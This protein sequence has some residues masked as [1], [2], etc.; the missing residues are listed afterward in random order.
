MDKS[1]PIPDI[2][3][4]KAT[5]PETKKQKRTRT[6]IAGVQVRQPFF[7]PGRGVVEAESLEEAIKQPQQEEVEH[8]NK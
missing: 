3:G 7:I 5:T 8:G 4:M 2:E 1:H 6:H